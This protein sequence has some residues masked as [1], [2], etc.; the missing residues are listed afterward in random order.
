MPQPITADDLYRF[1]WIDHV[2][3]DPAGERVAYQVVWA[4]REERENRSRILVR[5]LGSDQEPRVIA[6][7]PNDGSPEW[8]PSGALAFL[9]RV[10]RRAQLFVLPA[11]GGEPT[12]LTDLPDG[13]GGFRW[14]PDGSRIAFA[15]AAVGDPAHV[16]ED[17]RKPEL[18]EQSRRTPVARVATRLA[19]K[20]DGRG[21][22]NGRRQHIFV[23]DAAGGEPQQLTQGDWD[24]GSYSWA[25]D[26]QRLALTG[27][28]EPEGDRSLE[29]HVYVI[30][31]D[32]KLERLTQGMSAGSAEWSPDG[33]RIAFAAPSDLQGGR[34]DRAWV[35]AAA[36]GAPTCLTPD[37]DRSV[38]DSVITDMRG[39]HDLPLR[40]S[41][42]GERLVFPLSSPGS[43]GLAEVDADGHLRELVT[44]R[45]RV[46]DFDLH[47]NRIAFLCSD[48]SGPGDL[49]LVEDGREERLTSLNGW[50]SERYV[51][52]PERFTYAPPDGG[53]I[54]GWLL[55]PADFDPARKHPLVLEVHGGPH[56]QYGWAFFH[57]FQVLAGLGFC[58]LYVN[59]RGSDGYGEAFCQA[60]VRDWGG[61]DYRDLMAAVDHVVAQ[62]Y[63]DEARMGIGGGSYGGFMTNWVIGQTTRFGAAVAMRSISNLV[64]D[65]AQ[66]D[67]VPWSQA[68]MGP[69]PW[70]DLD[71]AW[72]RSPIRYVQNVTTPLLLTHGEMDLR[73]PISQAEEMFGALRLLGKEVELVRF[74]E[75]SHDL[76]RSGRPD[77]RVERLDRIAGWFTKHLLGAREGVGAGSEGIP[78]GGE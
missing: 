33:A 65:Y 41:E 18:E 10:K 57:E 63:V 35:V 14:S 77:R 74:P 44:G 54:E 68:E 27:N 43:A 38:G 11:G 42:G 34:L 70:P 28:A 6:A 78:V 56:G 39:G 32:G 9:R 5:E 58:V 30:G 23:I 3:L 1:E 19:Y 8:S 31:L 16:V 37:V 15:S 29:S 72:R 7:G 75:E 12:Q 51:A 24:V 47:G 25:P 52:Q 48:P 45:R 60:C 73:C 20:F 22:F 13:V 61:G 4:D 62:G 55:K 64:S 17:P 40:W 71:E 46:Y 53:E 49:F 59:P 67:I 36:G 50:L 26:G 69:P 76:S 21:Y 66:N 2:R